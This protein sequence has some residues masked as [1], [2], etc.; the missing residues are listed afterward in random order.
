MS[1]HHGWLRDE[2]AR[3]RTEGLIDDALA[4]RLLARYPAAPPRAWGRLVFSAIGAVLIGL[5]VTLFFAYNWND[6]PKAVKLALVFASLWAAHGGAL[7]LGRRADA[8]PGVVEGLHLLGTML[9]GSGIWLVAQIYHVDEHYPTAYLV[10]SL[11][12]LALAWAMPSIVQALLALALVAVWAGVEALDFRAPMHAAPLLA[13]LGTLPLAWWRRSPTLLFCGL[14]VTLTVTAFA[15][16][17]LDGDALLPVLLMMGAAA[18]IAGFAAGGSAFPEAEAPAR[19][20]G[21]T[22]VLVCVYALSFRRAAGTLGRVALD[23]PALLVYLGAA[24]IALA[25]ACWMLAR[26]GVD[27]LDRLERGQVALL[28]VAVAIVV[29]ILVTRSPVAGWLVALL[30]NAIALGLAALMILDGSQRLN[31][32]L[33]GTGCAVFAIVVLS[34]YLD[35]FSSLLAR[36]AAFVALGVGLFLVGNFYSRQRR[37]SEGAP[38]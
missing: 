12:A 36:A 4:V 21:L 3:W 28:G 10:W 33:V 13:A 27:R 20:A 25:A 11:G 1:T 5:G 24:A 16:A 17:G 2:V 8:H 37:Q 31:P 23:D 29:V 32:R 15:V 38:P 6:I 19:A 22:A 26:R 18:V 9:F 34:R 7:A 30:F 14:A 35:L